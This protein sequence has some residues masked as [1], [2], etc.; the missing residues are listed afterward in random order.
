MV[1]RGNSNADVPASSPAAG[2]GTLGYSAQTVPLYLRR[3]VQIWTIIIVLAAVLLWAGKWA[4]HAV[5]AWLDRRAFLAVQA[6]V[7]NCPTMPDR[8]FLSGGSSITISPP[9]AID[10]QFKKYFDAFW[11][12]KLRTL[13]SIPRG[14]PLFFQEL[15][16]KAGQHRLVAVYSEVKPSSASA[17]PESQSVLCLQMYSFGLREN[18]WTFDPMPPPGVAQ[19]MVNLAFIEILKGE[20]FALYG[21]AIDK[22]DSSH[23]TF[24]FMLNGTDHPLNAYLVDGKP[25]GPRRPA[26]LILRNEWPDRSWGKTETII[27]KTSTR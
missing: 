14:T 5:P 26:G 12:A 27:E 19:P 22:S 17:R 2:V 11:A 6:E 1:E 9:T 8:V 25:I 15:T 4:I 23:V 16:T 18:H 10:Q 24:R 7:L 3:R 21:G 20:T 13:S